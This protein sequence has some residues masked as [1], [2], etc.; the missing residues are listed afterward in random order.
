MDRMHLTSQ[1]FDGQLF[2]TASDGTTGN[3]LWV[4][5][6]TAEGTQRLVD[7]NPGGSGS[8]A[9]NF[10]EFDGQ[11]FFTADDGTTGSEPWVSDGTTEGTQR[12]VDINSFVNPYSAFYPYGSY[13]SYASNFTE[14]NGQLF[15]TANDGPTGN[16]LWVSDG[17]AEGT[18]TTCRYQ[19]R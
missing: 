14:F 10:T 15:F 5:D 2:F 9:S 3:E 16:E 1:N 19:S 6:G 17:T 4:S 11:L 8:N 12:L 7:I 18:T 13:G